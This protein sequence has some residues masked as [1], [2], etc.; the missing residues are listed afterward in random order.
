MDL[1]DPKRWPQI[2]KEIYNFCVE[3]KRDRKRNTPE[4]TLGQG[5]TPTG[6]GARGG[7]IAGLAGPVRWSLGLYEASRD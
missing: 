5:G 7:A 2:R 4:S 3:R 1:D 6:L